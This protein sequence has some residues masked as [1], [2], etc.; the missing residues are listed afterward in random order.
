[1]VTEPDEKKISCRVSDDT[2]KLYP[3]LDNIESDTLPEFVSSIGPD[4]NNSE[5]EL[6]PLLRNRKRIKNNNIKTWEVV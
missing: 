5:H 3:K 2:E 4:S 6:M 1:M